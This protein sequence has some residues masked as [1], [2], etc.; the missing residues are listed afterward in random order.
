MEKA[1]LRDV[2]QPT[3]SA[4]TL[5]EWKKPLLVTF[6]SLALIITGFVT[7]TYLYFDRIHQQRTAPGTNSETID[8]RSELGPCT[9]DAYNINETEFTYH[10]HPD[11]VYFRINGRQDTEVQSGKA[12]DVQT[13]KSKIFTQVLQELQTVYG[14]VHAP[15]LLSRESHWAWNEID[16]RRY[17]LKLNKTEL[18]YV[19][20]DPLSIDYSPD[21]WSAS[22]KDAKTLRFDCPSIEVADHIGKIEIAWVKFGQFM[23]IDKDVETL[24]TSSRVFK[25]ADAWRVLIFECLAKYRLPA[26]SEELAK[27]SDDTCVMNWFWPQEGLM[28]IR[29]IYENGQ[30][31]LE[32]RE[33]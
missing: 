10:L 14:F 15:E 26:H 31:S 23:Q 17:Y 8:H 22:V 2:E 4:R 16:S 19:I 12:C 33:K 20:S 11:E 1:P 9:A 13:T 27:C 32:E 18:S 28:F 29:I 24:L 3:K 21:E 7:Y 30:W 5:S 25:T 6:G